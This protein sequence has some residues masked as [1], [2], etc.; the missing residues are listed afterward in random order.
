MPE[1]LKG[2]KCNIFYLRSICQDCGLP[3]HTEEP[4]QAACLPVCMRE[5]EAK[6][7]QEAGIPLCRKEKAVVKSCT[8]HV[9]E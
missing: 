8:T 6:E 2:H 9:A 5:R 1:G 7:A 4:C 3:N